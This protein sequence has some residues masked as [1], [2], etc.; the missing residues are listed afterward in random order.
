LPL[1][2]PLPLMLS[3]YPCYFGSLFLSLSQANQK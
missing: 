3:G 2:W 1:I